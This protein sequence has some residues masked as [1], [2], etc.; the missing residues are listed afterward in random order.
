MGIVTFKT[1]ASEYWSNVG[2]SINEILSYITIPSDFGL[3]LKGS[4]RIRKIPRNTGFRGI[5]K[6]YAILVSN[7]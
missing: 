7:Q 3:D 2:A 4:G 6:W 1:T 5:G